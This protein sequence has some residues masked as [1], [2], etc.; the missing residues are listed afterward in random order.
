MSDLS[1]AVLVAL[2]KWIDDSPGYVDRDP[3]TVLWRR[4]S[5]ASMEANEALDALSGMVGENPRKGVY[6]TE[7]DVIRELL[8]TATA[9]LGAVEHMTGHRGSALE[10]LD[11]HIV[12][13]G[14]RAEIVR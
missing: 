8:D 10:M 13:V 12:S 7:A 2:S 6:A 14:K 3:E 4:V 1:S 9:A 11:Q 5:K